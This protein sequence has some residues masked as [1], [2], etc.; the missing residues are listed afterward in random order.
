[1][2]YRAP[3]NVEWCLQWSQAGSGWHCLI[4]EAT[5]RGIDHPLRKTP[6]QVKSTLVHVSEIEME[7]LERQNPPYPFIEGGRLT[8]IPILDHKKDNFLIHQNNCRWLEAFKV[9]AAHIKAQF[10]SVEN[11]IRQYQAR[12]A[13]LK[14]KAA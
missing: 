6:L 4:C 3:V 8:P 9:S 10:G 11:L 2:D 7:A 5:A 1:M 14:N 13:E 12:R